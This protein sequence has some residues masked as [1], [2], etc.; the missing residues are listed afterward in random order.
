[1]ETWCRELF[2]AL[3]TPTS[4]KCRCRTDEKTIYS[5]SFICT[6]SPFSRFQKSPARGKKNFTIIK[7]C[8]NLFIN[9]DCLIRI[10]RLMMKQGCLIVRVSKWMVLLPSF[11]TGRLIVSPFKSSPPLH[12]QDAFLLWIS[13]H[14]SYINISYRFFLNRHREG[15]T[16]PIMLNLE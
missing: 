10:F 2:V 1:M 13:R 7:N 8:V 12:S 3:V 6:I 15:K 14:I 16:Q 4:M 11:K 5:L 9:A